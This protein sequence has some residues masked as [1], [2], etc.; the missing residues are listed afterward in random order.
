VVVEAMVKAKETL[1]MVKMVAMVM[2]KV[3]LVVL[4]TSVGTIYD[5]VYLDSSENST[6]L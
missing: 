2:V 6:V 1:I 4:V 5:K 3:L